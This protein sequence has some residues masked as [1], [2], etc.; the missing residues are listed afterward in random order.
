MKKLAFLLFLLI[1]FLANAQKDTVH[2]FLSMGCFGGISG[3]QPTATNEALALAGYPKIPTQALWSFGGHFTIGFH[4]K[5]FD[6]ITFYAVSGKS[7]ANNINLQ[8][9]Q[10]NL[11][12]NINYRLWQHGRHS[13]YPSLGVGYQT[14]ELRLKYNTNPPDFTQSLNAPFTEKS[15]SNKWLLYLNPRISYD[16]ALNKNKTILAGIKAG[17]RIGLNKRNWNWQDKSIDGVK[18]GSGGYYVLIGLTVVAP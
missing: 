4:E 1:P 8:L 17:Y 12:V 6:D 11:D 18:M 16:I 13:F 9:N 7:S 14:N 10:Q 5:I 2:A 3:A 15:Y